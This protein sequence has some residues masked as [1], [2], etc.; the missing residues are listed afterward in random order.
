MTLALLLLLNAGG[1]K[2]A[3]GA[4]KA[5][6]LPVAAREALAKDGFTILEGGEK[7][8]FSLYDRNAYEKVPSFISADVILHVFHA[9]FDEELATFERTRLVA[10]LKTFSTGQLARALALWPKQ[11]APDAAL[12]ALTLFHAVAVALL[13]DGTPLDPRIAAAAN[14]DAKALRTGSVPLRSKACGTSLDATLFTPRG[15]SERFDL[16]GYF[17]AST[18]YAQCAFTLDRAGLPRAL[19]VLRLLDAPAFAALR[20]LEA[21]RELVAGPADDPGA[22]ELKAI[23]G[24]LP[25]FPQPLPAPALDAALARA[26]RL[27]RP[28]VASLRGP[29]F[30]LLGGAGTFDGEVLGAA[31]A[32]KR[33]PSALDVLAALNSAGALRLLG[34][35]PVDAGAPAT[36]TRGGGLAQRWL[37]VL[38]RLVGP[39]PAGQPPYALT[40]AWE[41]RVLTSAAASWAELKHDTLL[42]VKQPIVMREGGHDAELPAAKVGGYVDPRP[43]VYRELLALNDALR[44]LRPDDGKGVDPLGSFLHFVIEASLVELAGKPFPRDVDERLRTI[45]SELEHLARTRGDSTPPQALVADVLTIEFPEKPREVLHVGVGDVDELWVV[46]PR[47]GKQVLMRGGVFSYYEFTRPERLTDARFIDELASATPPSRPF[48]ARPVAKPPKKARKD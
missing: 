45:G 35:P 31:A 22:D 4:E 39:P 48:W 3:V 29:V 47:A 41:G 23:S 16:R 33:M 46:V 25:P 14:A 24:E 19:D 12:E 21:A 11:G 15:H 13:D 1:Y 40:S 8:F 42:Y 38:A 27:P 26:A 5:A 6:T 44:A 32:K 28:R 36:M 2:T 30:A 7:H 20:E 9:R 18:W 43:D 37:D 34:R 17:Q 10:A